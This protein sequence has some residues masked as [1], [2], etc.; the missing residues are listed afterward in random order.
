MMKI[1]M[2][3]SALS[4]LCFLPSGRLVCYKQGYISIY[5]AGK[6]EK[7]LGL[8]MIQRNV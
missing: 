5:N 8:L 3:Q 1:N 7:S 6:Q 2:L 4:P